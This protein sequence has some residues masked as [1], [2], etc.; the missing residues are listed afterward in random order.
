METRDPTEEI[1][2]GVRFFP[3]TGDV[4]VGFGKCRIDVDGAKDSVQTDA[5]P[6]CQYV[7]GNQVA[8]VFANE[9][10]AED[11]VLARYGQHLD[12]AMRFPIG[13]RPVEVVDFV[14]WATMPSS[15]RP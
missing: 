2:R 3:V 8:G 9:G 13:D 14:R 1:L 6:H 4:L 5:V 7:F 11:A 15:S 12:E 10:D